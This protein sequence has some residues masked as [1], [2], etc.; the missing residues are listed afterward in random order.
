M[1]LLRVLF[2]RIFT[3]RSFAPSPSKSATSSHDFAGNAVQS[4][5]Y[6]ASTVVQSGNR[7]STGNEAGD[8]SASGATRPVVSGAGVGVFDVDGGAGAGV[9]AGGA[10]VPGTGT[11]SSDAV[12]AAPSSCCDSGVGASDAV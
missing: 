6:F 10:E 7:T 9:V 3:A 12:G 5:R 11:F 1:P 8:A 2:S 4:R